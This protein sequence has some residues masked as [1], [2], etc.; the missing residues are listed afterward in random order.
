MKKLLFLLLSISYFTVSASHIIGG[1]FRR[2]WMTGDQY[3][4]ELILYYDIINSQFPGPAEQSEPSLNA[5]IFRR[6]DNT[7]VFNVTL[8]YTSKAFVSHSE[9]TCND[10]TLVIERFVYSATVTL[11]PEEFDSPEGYYIS[12]SRCCR[13][14]VLSNIYSSNPNGPDGSNFAGLTFYLEF[15]PVKVTDGILINSS[16]QV[17]HATAN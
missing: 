6:L 2:T 5:T 13:N 15:P 4:F 10:G 17:T 3:K 12:W 8:N 11:S 7:G 1:E 16:P 14:Y 9:S